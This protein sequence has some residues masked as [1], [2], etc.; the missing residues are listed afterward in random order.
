[1]NSPDCTKQDSPQS[2]SVQAGNFN[3]PIGTKTNILLD[4][5]DFEK[6]SE[7][8]KTTEIMNTDFETIID[9]AQEGDLIFADPPYT[10]KHNNNGFVKYNENMF[11]WEDQIR[12]HNA[13]VKAKNRNVKIIITNANHPSILELYSDFYKKIVSRSS[14]IAASSKN[15]GKYE[16]L[17]ISNQKLD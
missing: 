11:K 17:I 4:T 2:G 7:I 1:L 5:D 3:V 6:M 10:V 13:V 12:L 15:R 14:V 16:E 9:S 8:L